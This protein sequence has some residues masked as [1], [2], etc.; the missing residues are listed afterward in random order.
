MW[1]PFLPPK[2]VFYVVDFKKIIHYSKNSI[3]MYLPIWVFWSINFFSGFPIKITLMPYDI[4]LY[5]TTP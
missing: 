4:Y 5:D 3:D 2:L 1:E